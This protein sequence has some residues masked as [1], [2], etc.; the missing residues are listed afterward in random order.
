MEEEKK[1]LTEKGEIDKGRRDGFVFIASLTLGA[2]FVDLIDLV[3][4]RKAIS[5]DFLMFRAFTRVDDAAHRLETSPRLKRLR[6]N[7]VPDTR[8]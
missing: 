6:K 7:P 3:R 5:S 2:S 8:K 1:N 4:G